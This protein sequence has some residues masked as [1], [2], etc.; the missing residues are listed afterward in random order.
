M[1]AEELN[2]LQLSQSLDWDANSIQVQDRRITLRG[3]LTALY[4]AQQEDERILSKIFGKYPV[5]TD[6]VMWHLSDI[7]PILLN[8]YG[9]EVWNRFHVRI[10]ESLNLLVYKGLASVD[11]KYSRDAQKDLYYF[12]VTSL[13]KAF[14]NY[15][16]KTK[17]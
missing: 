7:L 11:T 1:T 5:T 6:D 16:E 9:L 8:G 15:N 12:A 17:V 14:V 13:G 10:Q 3:L 2:T 4:I